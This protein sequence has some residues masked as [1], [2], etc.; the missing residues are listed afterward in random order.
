MQPCQLSIMSKYNMHIFGIFDPISLYIKA[1]AS[2]QLLWITATKC[3]STR[4]KCWLTSTPGAHFC[5]LLMFNKNIVIHGLKQA[6]VS[7]G[8]EKQQI[9]T[10][11]CAKLGNKCSCSEAEGTES[12][13][14]GSVSTAQL[15]PDVLFSYFMVET[16]C[17]AVCIYHVICFLHSNFCPIVC[18]TFSKELTNCSEKFYDTCLF[19]SLNLY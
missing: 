16:L 6:N 2:L 13:C 3:T 18:P 15:S 9:S 19:A 14:E 4:G 5:F 7:C 12:S 8:V 17:A 10:W 11:I 1:S